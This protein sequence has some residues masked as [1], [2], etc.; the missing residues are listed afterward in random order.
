M[1]GRNCPPWTAGRERVPREACEAEHTRLVDGLLR[2]LEVE[3]AG[4]VASLAAT[5]AIEQIGTVEHS[6]TFAEFSQ[7]Y[8]E[9]FGAALS[10]KF[11]RPATR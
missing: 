1:G 7:R 6:Y 4:R 8:R 5:Y 3:E 9:A 2:G 10:Q 11:D